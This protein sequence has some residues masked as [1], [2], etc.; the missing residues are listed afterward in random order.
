LF[1]LKINIIVTTLLIYNDFNILLDV[2]ITRKY[3]QLT[4]Q[5]LQDLVLQM[6]IFQNCNGLILGIIF[7]KKVMIELKKQKKI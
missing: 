3:Q 5:S 2:L 6:F 1:L 7:G 4:N